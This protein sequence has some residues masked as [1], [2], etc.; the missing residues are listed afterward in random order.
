LSFS[1]WNINRFSSRSCEQR[2]H[3]FRSRFYSRS[4]I[5]PWFACSCEAARHER[6]IPDFS[7]V[8]IPTGNRL[9]VF[10]LLSSDYISNA[11]EVTSDRSDSNQYWW[12][13][14]WINHIRHASVADSTVLASG[15]CIDTIKQRLVAESVALLL[16]LLQSCWW[17]ECIGWRIG[18]SKCSCRI[19]SIAVHM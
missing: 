1:S 11:D 15:V 19:H 6:S 16:L 14:R 9:Y 17:E 12:R 7:V 8:S 2:G 13:Y 5:Y 10:D 4:S 18:S 3:N